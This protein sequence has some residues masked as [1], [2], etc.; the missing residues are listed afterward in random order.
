VLPS[1]FGLR[2]SSAQG[3]T[4]GITFLVRPLNF[5][6]VAACAVRLGLEEEVALG[7]VP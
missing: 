1:S 5:V 3:N 6:M 4:S 7:S 2:G